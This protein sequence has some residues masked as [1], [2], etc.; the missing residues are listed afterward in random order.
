MSI[1]PTIKESTL[2]DELPGDGQIKS[3]D[4]A[5][6]IAQAADKHLYHA[7]FL[8]KITVGKIELITYFAQGASLILN[9]VKL[10][11]DDMYAEGG[12][13]K[14]ERISGFFGYDRRRVVKEL[15]SPQELMKVLTPIQSSFTKWQMMTINE[16][17]EALAKYDESHL[18]RI[19]TNS[20]SYKAALSRPDKKIR[21]MDMKNE[22]SEWYEAE[23]N[24]GGFCYAQ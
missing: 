16:T 2:M 18:R 11:P 4:V 8:D 19:I 13:V 3:L 10:F 20:E 5:L 6:F 17:I 7:G 1:M 9:G 21:L 22:F 24:Y 23:N 15:P 12:S 14:T